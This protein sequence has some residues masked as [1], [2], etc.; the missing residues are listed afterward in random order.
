M[1]K[2]K[3]FLLNWVPEERG[4]DLRDDLL[5]L[6]DGSRIVGGEEGVGLE[7]CLHLA[8]DVGPEGEVLVL[9]LPRHQGDLLS[10]LDLCGSR[11]GPN[12]GRRDYIGLDL[13]AG[14]G[15]SAV[16]DDDGGVVSGG[17]EEGLC[18]KVHSCRG[19]ISQVW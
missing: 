6:G 2:P 8:V 10:A 18:L 3:Y 19:F 9:I 1:L 17:G 12:L 5:G 7:E 11:G 4:R 14:L 15:D 16:T 13:G